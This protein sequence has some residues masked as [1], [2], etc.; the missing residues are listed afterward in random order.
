MIPGIRRLDDIRP[1]LSGRP[2]GKAD[3]FSGIIGGAP[4]AEGQGLQNDRDADRMALGNERGGF[5]EQPILFRMMRIQHVHDCVRAQP[6]R[7]RRPVDAIAA[8]IRV[9]AM[10]RFVHIR[11]QTKPPPA[12]RAPR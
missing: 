3:V 8:M 11:P 6:H 9:A 12:R 10:G 1:E 4:D 5:F 2:N 7:F